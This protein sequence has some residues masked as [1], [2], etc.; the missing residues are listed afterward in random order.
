[1]EK[2]SN[3]HI[4]SSS[5]S[6]EYCPVDFNDVHKIELN[7]AADDSGDIPTA[8]EYGY[9]C[10]GL[11]SRHIHFIALGGSISTG[12]FLGI[13]RAFLQAGPLSALLGYTFTG[14]ASSAA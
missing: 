3:Y 2:S 9:V 5:Q 11:K 8:E 14:L 12:L 1:M 4:S 10:R 13:G 7:K 6:P